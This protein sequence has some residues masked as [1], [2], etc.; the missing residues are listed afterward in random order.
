MPGDNKHPLETNS[1]RQFSSELYGSCNDVSQE[2]AFYSIEILYYLRHEFN[3]SGKCLD[4]DSLNSHA[5]LL[6]HSHTKGFLLLLACWTNFINK[7]FKQLPYPV[8]PQKKTEEYC[9]EEGELLSMGQSIQSFQLFN[10]QK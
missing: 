5:V 8:C 9:Y 7:F 6:H 2:R 3:G 1:N 4:D 10:N